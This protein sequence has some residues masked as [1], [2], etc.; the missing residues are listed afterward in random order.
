MGNWDAA[1]G[2]MMAP[3]SREARTAEDFAWHR[4]NL[5]EHRL[6][7]TESE[8][9]WAIVAGDLNSP[10]SECSSGTLLASKEVTQAR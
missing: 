2:Q 3:S 8:A 5:I 9:G 4:Y 10:C 1:L 6:I 7:E